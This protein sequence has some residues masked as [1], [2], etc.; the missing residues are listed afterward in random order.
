MCPRHLSEY[1]ETGDD[2]LRDIKEDSKRME[3]V[4][5][6]SVVF[7]RS[8]EP[9]ATRKP[10]S[11]RDFTAA[12][13][14]VHEKALKGQAKITRFPLDQ[15][16][17]CTESLLN[18]ERSPSPDPEIISISASP[19]NSVKSELV[20][21][22]GVRA[23]QG[24]QWWTSIKREHDN[25]GEGSSRKKRKSEQSVTIDLTEDSNDDNFICFN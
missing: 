10:S 18:I 21:K 25:G 19:V 6:I 3:E 8:S 16:Q 24:M 13:A 4:G 15:N 2:K 14:N 7:H 23:L 9:T 12:I 1:L 17:S 22:E 11:R 20:K 5:E